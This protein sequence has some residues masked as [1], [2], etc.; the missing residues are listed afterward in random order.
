MPD[1][2]SPRSKLER[3]APS[4]T[5]ARN[6]DRGYLSRNER[7]RADSFWGSLVLAML[8]N[9]DRSPGSLIPSAMVAELRLAD[10]TMESISCAAKRRLA[11]RSIPVKP[12]NSS[13]KR[14]T[15]GTS[16][17]S[18]LR[19]RCSIGFQIAEDELGRSQKQL[20]HV[21]RLVEFRS[22]PEGA[23]EDAP[24]AVA[25]DP[26]HSVVI[27]RASRVAVGRLFRSRW[28]EAE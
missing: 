5:C 24:F 18:E 25:A 20:F 14:I 27:V 1:R 23:I 9:A 17:L 7:V 6:A 19:A 10:V 16:F 11:A 21:G 26:D 4:A 2:K 22:M 12:D 15:V 8:I 3:A 28:I 13:K